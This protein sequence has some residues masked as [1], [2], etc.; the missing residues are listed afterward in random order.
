MGVLLFLAQLGHGLEVYYMR[1]PTKP[2]ATNKDKRSDI[3]R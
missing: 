1:K 2:K 3:K